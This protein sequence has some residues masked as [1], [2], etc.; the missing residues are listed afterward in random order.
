MDVNQYRHLNYQLSTRGWKK[1]EP[2]DETLEPESPRLLARMA[3]VAH[4]EKK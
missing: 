4:G 1:G 2:G 3:D